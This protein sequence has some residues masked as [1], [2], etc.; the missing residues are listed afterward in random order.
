MT[1]DVPNHPTMLIQFTDAN[2]LP[3]DVQPGVI[4][5]ILMP[6]LSQIAQSNEVAVKATYGYQTD[7]E[8]D[9]VSKQIESRGD[10]L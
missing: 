8:F 6:I 10:D 5:N 7:N 4:A 3:I 1:D 9:A 2:G